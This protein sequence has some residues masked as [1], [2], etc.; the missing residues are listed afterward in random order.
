MKNLYELL[1]IPDNATDYEIYRAFLKIAGS[2]KYL[3]DN[4]KKE[5]INAF[6]ILSDINL[7]KNYDLSIGLLITDNCPWYS[8]T[9]FENGYNFFDI[10]GNLGGN[11]ELTKLIE[12]IKGA[13]IRSSISKDAFFSESELINCLVNYTKNK[14]N[15]KEF[16]SY[17]SSNINCDNLSDEE[18]FAYFKKIYDKY[19]TEFCFSQSFAGAISSRDYNKMEMEEATR[20]S[21]AQL[22]ISKRG[23][24][25]HFAS[26]IHEELKGLGIESYFLRM[27]LPNWIHHVVLYRINKGWYICD[28]TNEYLFGNAGYKITDKN[29]MSIPLEEFVKNNIYSVETSIVPRYAGDTLINEDCITLKNFIETRIAEQLKNK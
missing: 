16:V 3:D 29:Y 17:L 25:T 22:L 23:V 28:L 4:I 19:K 15:N 27:T 11:E 2:F 8:Y 20:Y 6:I 24:C 7:R 13:K 18:K 21:A 9:Y 5:Y 1:Q 26:L 10:Y 14:M 12:K